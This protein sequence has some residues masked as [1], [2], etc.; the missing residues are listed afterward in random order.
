[1]RNGDKEMVWNIGSGTFFSHSEE[2]ESGLHSLSIQR[3]DALLYTSSNGGTMPV[4]NIP[5][6]SECKSGIGILRFG[7]CFFEPT[8]EVICNIS[9]WRRNYCGNINM[10][11]HRLE[12]LTI[13]SVGSPAIGFSN[14]HNFMLCTRFSRWG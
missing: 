12:N 3:L 7:Y 5:E 6:L 10:V 2:L 11:R 13:D 8:L 9:S 4:L 14:R 1:M